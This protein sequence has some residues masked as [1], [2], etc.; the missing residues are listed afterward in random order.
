MQT[1]ASCSSLCSV[2]VSTLDTKQFL[3]RRSD[4]AIIVALSVDKVPGSRSQLCII[5]V[6]YRCYHNQPDC[7][8]VVFPSIR[9]VIVDL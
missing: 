7:K 8:R 2:F 1:P 6:C 3:S 5:N 9:K 4:G